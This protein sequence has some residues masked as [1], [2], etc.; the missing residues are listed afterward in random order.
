MVSKH[1]FD[2]LKK[3][4]K[5][6]CPAGNRYLINKDAY[7][8]LSNMALATITLKKGGVREPHWHPNASELTYCLQGKAL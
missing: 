8:F 2:L 6:I 3:G 4:I 5:R 1:K 7:P